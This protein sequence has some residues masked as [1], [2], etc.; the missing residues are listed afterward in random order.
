MALPPSW[1][2][3]F[4]IEGSQSPQ[5]PTL[6]TRDT[7][8]NLRVGQE[9]HLGHFWSWSCSLSSSGIV[10]VFPGVGLCLPEITWSTPSPFLSPGA[11]TFFL[12]M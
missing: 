6:V 11:M 3:L 7:L 1:Q 8:G 9:E 5:L 4:V 2:E 12:S 10:F